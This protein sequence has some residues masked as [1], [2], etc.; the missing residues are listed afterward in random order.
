MSKLAAIV[1]ESGSGKS[2][3]IKNLDPKETY[4]I[5]VAGKEL[6]FKGSSKIYNEDNRNY[7]SLS[8]AKEI[9]D[10]CKIISAD[11]KH[12]KT[13]I[14]ED[15]NYVMGFTLV[16]K[17]LETGFTK[18]S[19]MAKDMVNL[20]QNLKTLR[21]DLIIYYITHPEVQKDGED[22]ISY[23]IK[24]AGKAL[25]NQIVMEGL[26][27]VVLYTHLETK[28]DKTEYT[29]VTNRYNKYPAKSP[30]EMFND[31]KIPNDLTIVNKAIMEYYN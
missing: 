25:D 3:S 10:L 6:P 21:D 8:G 1:G 20:I 26:F 23:K 14:I 9:L 15:A 16:N 18:F 11:A 19:L 28:G 27:T 31:I 13:I 2:T 29:F 17:A 4:I 5:N 24:T 22:I 7:K 12:V 30:M